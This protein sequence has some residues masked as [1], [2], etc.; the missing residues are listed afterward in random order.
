MDRGANRERYFH[1]DSGTG[2]ITTAQP[3]DRESVAVHNITVVAA[4][5]RESADQSQGPNLPRWAELNE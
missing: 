2:V 1:I 4:E 5:R 3:L